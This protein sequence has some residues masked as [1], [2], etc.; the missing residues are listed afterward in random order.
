MSKTYLHRQTG[1]RYEPNDAENAAIKTLTD[2]GYDN[3]GFKVLNPDTVAPHSLAF[4]A[5]MS[6][7]TARRNGIPEL[8]ERAPGFVTAFER[9]H[10]LWKQVDHDHPGK[11]KHPLAPIVERCLIV[12]IDSATANV[13]AGFAPLPKTISKVNG[14]R[15][16]KYGTVDSTIV[17]GEPIASRL[18]DLGR[19]FKPT[20]NRNKKLYV[21]TPVGTEDVTQLAFNMDLAHPRLPYDIP[22]P[23]IA[24]SEYGYDLRST[25]AQDTAHLLTLIYISNQILSLLP[26]QGAHY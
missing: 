21:Y 20:G 22:V 11:Y 5:L 26:E 15:W 7:L 17:D 24:Y 14:T 19:T 23:L 2:A 12:P 16:R 4:S 13:T 6:I 1:K 10:N 18:P 9:V 25:L 3:H 8:G